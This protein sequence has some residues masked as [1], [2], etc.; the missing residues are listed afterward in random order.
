[1]VPGFRSCGFHMAKVVIFSLILMYCSVVGA[2]GQGRPQQKPTT[3]AQSSESLPTAMDDDDQ[4]SLPDE[5]RTRMEIARAES[6]H[7]KLVDE[8]KQMTALSAELAKTYKQAARLTSAEYK[9]IA[10]IEKLAKRILSESG[11]AEVDEAQDKPEHLS[12]AEAIEKLTASTSHVGEKIQSETRFVVSAAVVAGSNE[13][14]HLTQYIR[15][16]QKL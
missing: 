12:L 6:E 9:K 13:V 11:G 1:M 10:S 2:F 5:M 3:G 4:H 15:R 7:K 14:I 16:L 8:A